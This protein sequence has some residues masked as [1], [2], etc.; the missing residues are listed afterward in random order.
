MKKDQSPL[1]GG[2]TVE[3]WNQL[4]VRVPGGLKGHQS[5]LTDEVGLY[6]YTLSRRSKALGRGT[7]KKGGIA[8]RLSDFIRLGWS[9]RSHHVGRLIFEHRDRLEV[10][11]LITGSGP[12]A[13]ELARLLKAP[14]VALHQPDWNVRNPRS[15]AKS[16]A[17]R[18]RPAVKATPVP[19]IYRLPKPGEAG[20]TQ[21]AA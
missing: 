3:E 14:M 12:Y 19:A 17:R 1:I 16:K 9:G 10:W 2:K 20:T 4:W 6:H 15:V 8:K 5:Q 7:D 11:V 21:P 18:L 13:R